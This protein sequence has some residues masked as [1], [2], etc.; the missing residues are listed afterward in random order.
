VTQTTI[1]LTVLDIPINDY[2]AD[3]FDDKEDENS[4]K[5]LDA[6]DS[7]NQDDQQNN[8]DKDESTK[9]KISRPSTSKGKRVFIRTSNNTDQTRTVDSNAGSEIKYSTADKEDGPVTLH[10]NSRNR[11]N[12]RLRYVI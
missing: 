12:R 2:L 10:E 4:Q 8:L 7:N 11:K 9:N 6:L 3:I 5:P 1:K